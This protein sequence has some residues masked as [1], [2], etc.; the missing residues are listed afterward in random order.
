MR[1]NNENHYNFNVTA[2]AWPSQL[3]S[4]FSNKQTSG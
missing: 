3:W 2:S 1:L 4:K